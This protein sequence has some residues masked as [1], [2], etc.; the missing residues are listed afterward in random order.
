LYSFFP[1][2]HLLTYFPP[3]ALRM[4]WINIESI[5]TTPQKSKSYVNHGEISAVEH[6]A[7]RLLEEKP[8]AKIAVLTFYKAQFQE[9]V[10]ASSLLQ[11]E[12]F[13]AMCFLQLCILSF[14]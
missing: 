7:S 13:H 8:W 2:V 3:P 5:E 10:Q 11:I 12:V 4:I 9:L 6:V 1:K 14:H